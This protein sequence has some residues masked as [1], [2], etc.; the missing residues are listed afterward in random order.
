[1]DYYSVI[2]L[3]FTCPHKSIYSHPSPNITFS[4]PHLFG[5]SGMEWYCRFQSRKGERGETLCFV[6]T[7]VSCLHR[8][9]HIGNTFPLT[10]D[11]SESPAETILSCSSL[12]AEELWNSSASSY[13]VWGISSI[14]FLFYDC[15]FSFSLSF[16]P[17]SPSC[18]PFLL[19]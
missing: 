2:E 18:S 7:A 12:H 1:M 13:R 3:V 9:R 11:L 5:S 19:V 15:V 8:K 6:W 4:I 14:I 10:V 16:S 17:S